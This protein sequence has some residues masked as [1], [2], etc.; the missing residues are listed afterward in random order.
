MEDVCIVED[1]VTSTLRQKNNSKSANV[2]SEMK[3]DKDVVL[4]TDIPGK[5][6]T[7]LL[8]TEICKDM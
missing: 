7:A 5:S 4:I 1:G 2:T 6:E 8:C 3:T